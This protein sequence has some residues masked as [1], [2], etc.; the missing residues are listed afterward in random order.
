MA[1]ARAHGVGVRAGGVGVIVCGKCGAPIIWC[2]A[3]DG[4][5]L[6]VDKEPVEG[7][8]LTLHQAGGRTVA[9][10]VW[11]MFETEERRARP[12]YVAHNC[13]RSRRERR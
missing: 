1:R 12:H 6:A 3:E 7:G 8:S 9:L 2:V 11:P 5:P 10:V 4:S 13:H